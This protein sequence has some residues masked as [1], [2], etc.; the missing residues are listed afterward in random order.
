LNNRVGI[1]FI[2][3]TSMILEQNKP[4]L[5]FEKR[6]VAEVSENEL[7]NINGGSTP[8]QLAAAAAAVAYAGYNFGHWLYTVTH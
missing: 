6:M 4:K 3:I 8:I 7:E 2:N 1:T 5:L